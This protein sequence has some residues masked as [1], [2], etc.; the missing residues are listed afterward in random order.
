MGCNVLKDYWDEQHRQQNKKALTGST[1]DQYCELFGIT[2][3]FL[4]DKKILEVGVGL[5]KA[6]R[7]LGTLTDNLDVLDIS[8]VALSNVAGW[9]AR[10][11][12]TVKEL[13]LNYYDVVLSHL[14][15]QHMN[16]SD[17]II[18]MEHIIKSLVD[19]GVFYMQWADAYTHNIPV[20]FIIEKGG[21]VL[22]DIEEMDKLVNYAG[23][24]LKIVTVKGI[25]GAVTWY[26]GAIRRK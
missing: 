5:G 16:D 21:G 8:L 6:T 12:D 2:K 22:R 23:G 25:T 3:K 17:L 4:K 11:Y 1:L 24:D 9:V 10:G 14:V 18:Q 15:A 19:N 7:E 26:A 13:P 20:D